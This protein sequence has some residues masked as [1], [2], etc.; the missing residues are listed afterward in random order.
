MDSIKQ[1]FSYARQHTKNIFGRSQNFR[2][3]YKMYFELS[4][5]FQKSVW[6][7]KYILKYFGTPFVL[8]NSGRVHKPKSWSAF[9]YA[10]SSLL[11]LDNSGSHLQN[12]QAKAAQLQ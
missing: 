3:C 11:I 8:Y 7:I 6:V 9:S 10:P 5:G 2:L 1:H 4:L 12:A